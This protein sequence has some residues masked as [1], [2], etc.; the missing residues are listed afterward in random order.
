[1]EALD[2]AEFVDEVLFLHGVI[3][4]LLRSGSREMEVACVAIFFWYG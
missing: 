1:M 2:F 3:W 4:P